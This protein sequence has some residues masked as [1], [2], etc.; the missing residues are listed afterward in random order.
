MASACFDIYEPSNQRL[1]ISPD[2]IVY[3]LAGFGLLV[4]FSPIDVNPIIK[5]T[6]IIFTFGIAFYFLIAKFWSYEPLYGKMGGELVFELE[7]ITV[8]GYRFDIN[9]IASIDFRLVDFY[10]RNI[11]VGRSFN[12]TRSQ[13]VNNYMQ[14]TDTSDKTYIIYFRLLR[15][16]DYKSLEPFLDEYHRQKKM[17]FK[18]KY[19]LERTELFT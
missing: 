14:L 17:T 12:A 9:K 11:S 6:Y 1:K 16:T 10:G 19:E 18:A 2:S 5:N 13:G 3:S 8:K 7:A 15:P 4:A